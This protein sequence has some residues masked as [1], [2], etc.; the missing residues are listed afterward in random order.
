[1]HRHLAPRGRPVG[2]PRE[3]HRRHRS[4]VRQLLNVDPA[5][6]PERSS[7]RQW[8]MCPSGGLGCWGDKRIRGPRQRRPRWSRPPER[9]PGCLTAPRCAG[10]SSSAARR[11]GV[12]RA[13]RWR[14][15]AE[16]YPPVSR[17]GVPA[18]PPGTLPGG[19]Q[20]VPVVTDER[21]QKHDERFV[22]A[23]G[24]G[25][26]P[27]AGSD[28]PLRSSCRLRREALPRSLSGQG[29]PPSVRVP[30]RPRAGGP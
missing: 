28:P 1:M 12:R 30:S 8:G 14:R 25:A 11:V 22:G 7:R 24:W 26:C 17:R 19:S 23:A 3:L 13:H 9:S 21:E 6:G 10:S 27:R 20:R 4:V 5:D 2:R 18:A 15:G 16:G 29:R